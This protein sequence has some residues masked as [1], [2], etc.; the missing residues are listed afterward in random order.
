MGFGDGGC[1]REAETLAGLA[2]AGRQEKNR[3][4]DLVPV[5]VCRRRPSSSTEDGRVTISSRGSLDDLDYE[6]S[7]AQTRWRSRLRLAALDA[8]GLAEKR[9]R[10]AFDLKCRGIGAVCVRCV[11]YFRRK[12]CP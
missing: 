4:T 5:R 11:R 1:D 3:S 12:S 10:L 8:C 7:I 2:S 9:D 6:S